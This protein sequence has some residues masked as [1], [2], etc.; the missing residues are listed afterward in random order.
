MATVDGTS[1]TSVGLSPPGR[2]RGR[3]VFTGPQGASYQSDPIRTI[4]DQKAAG[5]G[6]PTSDAG[7]GSV[8]LLSGNLS[9]T[10]D[11]FSINSFISDLTLSRTYNSRDPDKADR[12]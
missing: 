3:A 5:K 12:A 2:L 4:L 11:D 9:V 7:P 8:D 6:D 10:R 1:Q